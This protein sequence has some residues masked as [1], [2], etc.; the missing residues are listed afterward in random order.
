MRSRI[1]Q[2]ERQRA[3]SH[4]NLTQ[5]IPYREVFIENRPFLRCLFN[6]MLCHES[7]DDTQGAASI[8]FEI[9]ALDEEDRMGARMELPKHLTLTPATNESR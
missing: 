7:L 1:Q 4:T 8:Y 3:T 2:W 6:L 9:L 5:T